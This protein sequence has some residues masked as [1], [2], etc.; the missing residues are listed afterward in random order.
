[1][2]RPFAGNAYPFDARGILP[3]GFRHFAFQPKAAC[4]KSPPEWHATVHEATTIDSH[5]SGQIGANP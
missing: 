4:E 1:M 5:F 3:D 2:P